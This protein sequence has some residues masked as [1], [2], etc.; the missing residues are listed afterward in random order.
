MTK[1][2]ADERRSPRANVLLVAAIE[3]GGMRIPVKVGNISAHGALVHGDVVPG[4]ETPV[5]FRCNGHAIESW[6]AWARAP[7]AGIQFGE[8][9][10]PTDVL[11][12]ATSLSHL[13]SSDTRKVDFKRP[14]FRCRQLSEEERKIIEEWR[15]AQ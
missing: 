11:R 3:S 1:N 14:G 5:V 12:K 9:I 2:S 6:V 15:A 8:A 4:E 10:R 7:Q 13:V